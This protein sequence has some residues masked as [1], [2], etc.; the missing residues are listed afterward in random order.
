MRRKDKVGRRQ[1]HTRLL[2]FCLESI[3]TA[4]FP[5]R[6]VD[7]PGCTHSYCA[8]SYKR[9][10]GNRFSQSPK[11][12]TV[13][14]SFFLIFFSFLEKTAKQK[15]RRTLHTPPFTTSKRNIIKTL[16]VKTLPAGQCSRFGVT[17]KN[18]DQE[19]KGF[20]DPTEI[21]H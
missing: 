12:S 14:A 9:N 17:T 6:A 10:G 1:R 18:S 5:G 4:S 11:C 3:I 7:V 15:E 8:S 13:V 21:K 20:A 2:H 19:R 16:D